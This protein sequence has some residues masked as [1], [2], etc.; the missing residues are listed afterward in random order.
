LKSENWRNRGKVFVSRD[1]HGR[2]KTWR[3]VP[4]QSAFRSDYGAKSVAIYGYASIDWGRRSRRYEFHGNGRDI[5]RAVRLA[6]RIVPKDE[7]RY[8]TVSA[9]EF[10]MH[11]YRYGK[12]GY[13]IDKE[14]ES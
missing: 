4:A 3:A 5:F 14:I 7:N 10:L 12:E 1:E 11:P 2:F 9:R 8:V 6:L 13:W